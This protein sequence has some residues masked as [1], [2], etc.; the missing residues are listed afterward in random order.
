MVAFI[1]TRLPIHIEQGSEG[2]AGYKTDIWVGASGKESR[3]IRWSRSRGTWNIAYGI[4]RRDDLATIKSLHH[5]AA[6]AALGFRFKDW[7]D[8]EIG[9]AGTP[10]QIATGDGAT[11]KFQAVKI[12]TAGASSRARPITRLV[13]GTV[14]VFK[15]GVEVSSGVSVDVDTGVVTFT[16]A[17]AADVV[18]GLVA[19]FDVPVRFS[20]DSLPINVRT[21]N[22]ESIPDIELI[23]IKEELEDLS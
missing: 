12:Y 14:S 7:S 6:G 9:A 10:Q 5:A 18:I 22:L 23:E 21:A 8:Y 4:H 20:D 17:P 13:D 2:G 15:D 1:D 16:T 11:T 3:N 19:E